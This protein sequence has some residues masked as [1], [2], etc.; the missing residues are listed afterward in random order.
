MRS[1]LGYPVVGR[2]ARAPR[3]GRRRT[4][5]AS[6]LLGAL[7]V[8]AS[9]LTSA[10]AD[11]SSNYI[12]DGTNS[13]CSDN[14]SGAGSASQPFCTIAGAA[15]K[16]QPGDTVSVIAGTYT[17]TGVNPAISGAA[18]SPITF[19][20]S[21]GVTISAGTKAFALSSRNYIVISGFTITGTSS[22][23]ISVSNGSNDTIS[24]NTITGTGS[25]AIYLSGG[26]NNT[27]SGNTESYAGTPQQGLSA[28]GIWLNNETSDLVKGNVTHDNSAHGI[29]L[30]GTTTGALV[31]GNTSYHNAYQWERNANGINDIA[32]GNS[33]IG[34]V[35]YA[36]EDSGIN[37]YPGG[38]NALVASNVTYGNGDHGIDDLNVT[39][40]R[41]IGNTVYG[42]CS[43][44][45]NVEGTSSNYLIE[46][47]ISDNNATGAEVSPTIVNYSPYKTC[48]QRRNGNIGVYD[49]TAPGTTTADYNL[50]YQSGSAPDFIWGTASY[51]SWQAICNATGQECHHSNVADPQFVN[52]GAANFQLTAGSPAIDQA[53][54]SVSGQ[55]PA[56]ILG[57]SPYDDQGA[58]EYAGGGGTQTGPT[59]QLTV[60]P[61]AGT[62][63]LAV[64]ADASGS[65]AGS[66][67]ISS[68][69][70]DFGDGTTVGPQPG[71]T[72]SHT[73]TAP[74]SYIVKVTATDGNGLTSQANQAVTVN[75]QAT[76]PTARL[77]VTPSSGTAP[78][79]V[80]ADASAS[81]AGSSPISSYSFT[82]GDGSAQVGPQSGATAGHTY[83]T[84]GT[85]TVTVTATDG[86]GLTSQAT[87]TVTVSP[88]SSSPAKYVNQIATNYSTNSHTSGYVTVYRTA[89]VA[90]GDMIIAT[91]QLTGTSGGAAS[92]T[93]SKGDTL[94]V[95]SDVSDGNGDR[96]ITVAG[97]AVN[98]L[99]ANDTITI[100]FPTASGYHMTADE[101]SGVTSVDQQSAA[102]GTSSAFSS[103]STGTT[104]RSGEFVY[105]TV[106]TFGGTSL[107]WNSGWSALSSYTVGSTAI[108]RAYQIPKATGTF[109]ASGTASG[110]W[111]AQVVTFQ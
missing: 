5:A 48:A 22:Y 12:V 45:I 78:L 57:V 54:T 52:A 96:L 67:P 1:L 58:Y 74:G 77:S 99:A 46:N 107:S 25:H 50:V 110:S 16:A 15:K 21:P 7:A 35:T 90:A 36:N 32:P 83:T 103:G 62:A 91:V 51:T 60:S 69:T 55:Q 84:A 109:T 105:A 93:D 49:T 89:G 53:N 56:D 4:L 17:G 75:P 40:G 82:F 85:Y 106:A 94:S 26:S 39:G 34:N 101:V 73:Y 102:S 97:I 20:A 59:A 66:S 44:G 38:D 47:N 28:Y 23:G 71:A 10:S 88:Q 43:D 98:G 63:P 11:A 80:T 86:N 111:L 61:P 6:T 68:Y 81:T 104:A 72:T 42:N 87:Q 41:I 9:F 24:G 100:R 37:V 65:T 27:V 31:E 8:G 30:S 18:G 64:T 92:G 2:A 95:V 29:Y 108:G 13:L 79:A 19:T 70:F 3:P 76:G 14:G 33:L